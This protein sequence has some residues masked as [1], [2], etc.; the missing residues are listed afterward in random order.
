[1]TAIPI[2]VTI[3]NVVK[4][5]YFAKGDSMDERFRQN[6]LFDF[7]GELLN[8]H[9]KAVFSAAIFDDMSYS[10]LAEEFDCSRQAAFDLVR[11]IDKKLEDYESKLGLLERFTAARQRMDS[12]SLSVNEMQEIVKSSDM[13]QKTRNSLNKHLTDISNTSEEIFDKF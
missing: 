7:Y 8:N 2:F 9:Q 12:L 11:R 5:N 3:T 1:M 4:E 6:L 13:D 10:E